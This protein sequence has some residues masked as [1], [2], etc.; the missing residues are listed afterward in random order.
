MPAPAWV[1]FCYGLE[2]PDTYTLQCK[3]CGASEKVDLPISCSE[4]SRKAGE[5]GRDH[6]ECE[7]KDAT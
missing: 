4:L 5:F 2:G 7:K 1:V 3:R 6:S